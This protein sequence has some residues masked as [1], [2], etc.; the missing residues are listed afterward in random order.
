VTAP[1]LVLATRDGAFAAL[2]ESLLDDGA[3]FEL[4]VA[5]STIELLDVVRQH[6]PDAVLLDVDGQDVAAL[7]TLAAKVA[8]VSEAWVILVSGY[9]SPGSTGLTSLLQSIAGAAVQKPG[10]ATSPSLAGKDGAAFVAAL[11]GAFAARPGGGL[12]S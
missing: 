4:V 5:T 11:E 3:T 9:L 12:P 2:C 8:L 1:T 6:D 10:G 7:K